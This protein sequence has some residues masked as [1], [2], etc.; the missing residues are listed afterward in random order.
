MMHDVGI[1]TH[2]C[3]VDAIRAHS[4]DLFISDVQIFISSGCAEFDWHNLARH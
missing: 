3:F 2:V 1:Y 4:A